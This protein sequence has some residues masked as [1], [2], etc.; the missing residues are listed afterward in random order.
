ME[1]IPS[2][3]LPRQGRPS[4]SSRS[5][6]LRR[7]GLALALAAML[8]LSV[9]ACSSS[10]GSSDPSGSSSS[11]SSSS[12]SSDAQSNADAEFVQCMRSH[13]V[14]NMPNANDGRFIMG[15]GSNPQNN[16]NWS[17]AV[18]ACQHFMPNGTLGGNQQNT[19]AELNYAHCMQTHGVPQYP[20]PNSDGALVA[21]KNVDMNSPT[22]KAA[23]QDCKS[24]LPSGT[25]APG[26]GQ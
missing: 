19:T 25:Q 21:P 26:Q 14:T 6:G 5:A 11:G 16:P 9:A 8:G 12:N 18:Q 4:R 10:S 23:Q 3:P 15:G 1:A 7:A 20:D 24:Y 17:S 22:V 13:G 2:A